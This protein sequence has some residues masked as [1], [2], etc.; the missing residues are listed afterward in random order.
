MDGVLHSSQIDLQ[1]CFGLISEY[2]ILDS[3]QLYALLKK[4]GQM[5]KNQR[6]YIVKSL[7]TRGL[8]R[9][10]SQGGR[11]YYV[12]APG[13]AP[14]SKYKAQIICFWVLLEYIGKVDTHYATGTFSRIGVEIDGRDYAIVY[15]EKGQERLCNANMQA[16][17]DVRY[18][19]VVEA[20][21]QIPLIVGDKIHTF[22]TVSGE[23]K[24]EYYSQGE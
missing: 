21:E 2:K 8:A 17:G 3:A 12:V 1:Y 16:G 7:Q 5:S 22:A 18:F 10:M 4:E 23:G 11:K 19:V 15:V 9:Q 14:T 20:V 6:H 24:V 13:I